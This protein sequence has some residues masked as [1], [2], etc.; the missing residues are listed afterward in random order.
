V[1]GSAVPPASAIPP[2]SGVPPASGLPPGLTSEEEDKKL[3]DAVAAR[4]VRMGLAV[5]AIFFLES[6]KPLSYV[7]SQVLVFLEPFV[8]SVLTVASYDRF[9]ALLEDRRNIEKLLRRIEDMDEE[10]REREKEAKK[11]AKAEK[12]QANSLGAANEAA[13]RAAGLPEDQP[14][15]RRI[16]GR[17]RSGRRDTGD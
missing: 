7:G 12:L 15:W 11:L 2:A 14:R 16:L 4:V 10:T 8:K 9:V 5:P 3:I 17:V 6:T 13:R 1:S